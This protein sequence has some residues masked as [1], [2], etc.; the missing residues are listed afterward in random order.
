MSA[1]QKKLIVHE[2]VRGWVWGLREKES[3]E[4][5]EDQSRNNIPHVFVVHFYVIKI[6][7][8]VPAYCEENDQWGLSPG[9]QP[10]W[11]RQ[12]IILVSVK[13]A[14]PK[15]QLSLNRPS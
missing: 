9:L 14:P 10:A 4:G 11:T 1:P 13:S 7:R 15:H 12:K 5:S 2:W 3:R 8:Q 6:Y